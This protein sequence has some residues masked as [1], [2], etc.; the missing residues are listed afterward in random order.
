MRGGGGEPTIFSKIIKTYTKVI[1]IWVIFS[2]GLHALTRDHNPTIVQEV[3][4]YLP[5]SAQ[6]TH[7]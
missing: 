1:T 3:T 4:V 7:L 6:L 2:S 5:H